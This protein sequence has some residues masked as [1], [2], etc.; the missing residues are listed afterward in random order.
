LWSNAATHTAREN[1]RK[2]GVPQQPSFGVLDEEAGVDEF[3]GTPVVVTSVRP[4]TK[5][6]E[7]R[8]PAIQRVQADVRV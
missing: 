5:V 3:G 1:G 4:E 8:P 7:L 2:A 6:F